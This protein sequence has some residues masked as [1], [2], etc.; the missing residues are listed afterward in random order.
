[1]DNWKL[2][3]KLIDN[4][5]SIQSCWQSS[6]RSIPKTLARVNEQHHK[7]RSQGERGG[8]SDDKAVLHDIF[9]AE[10]RSRNIYFLFFTH[11]NPN[12]ENRVD[13]LNLRPGK[14]A[15]CTVRPNE[16]CNS[17]HTIYYLNW[18]NTG[19]HRHIIKINFYIKDFSIYNNIIAICSVEN[20][21]FVDI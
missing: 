7:L 1:M 6:H 10:L 14:L 19:L 15:G 18:P 2:L 9:Y 20:L 5:D 16:W 3:N 13:V 8:Q 11:R 4:K 12:S 21:K 17:N